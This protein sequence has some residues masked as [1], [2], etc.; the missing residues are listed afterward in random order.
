MTMTSTICSLVHNAIPAV[1]VGLVTGAACWL[2]KVVGIASPAILTGA[3]FGVI[4]ALTAKLS[5]E[6]FD[7]FKMQENLKWALSSVI[8][9]VTA[10]WAIGLVIAPVTVPTAVVLTIIATAAL[11]WKLS[12]A[13]QCGSVK[14]YHNDL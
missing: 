14:F 4:A 7:R 9:G 13:S 8:S 2:G 1:K 3:G 12:F 11:Q 5:L 10:Y 6:I